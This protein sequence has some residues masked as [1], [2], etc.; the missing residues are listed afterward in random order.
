MSNSPNPYA[1]PTVQVPLNP[2]K[3]ETPFELA[4]RG[5]RF[6]NY[7]IDWLV[8]FGIAFVIGFMLVII[9]GEQAAE[10]IEKIP[11][12]VLSIPILFGYYFLFEVTTSRT[13]GKLLT[14]TKVVD[15]NGNPPSAGQIAGRTLCR[16]IPFEAFSFFGTPVRGW[17]DSIPKT[18]VIKSR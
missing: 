14:G 18:Y 2:Y 10:T 6:C 5:L 7:F 3:A 12:F 11:G 17:H 1:A 16:M 9:G 8:Q 4:P 13:L 15:E